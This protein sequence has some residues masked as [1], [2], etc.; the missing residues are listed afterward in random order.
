MNLLPCPEFMK[1]L[2]SLI[3]SLQIT[4]IEEAS[5]II[6]TKDLVTIN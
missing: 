4:N 6:K 5:D 1:E 2:Q 3:E